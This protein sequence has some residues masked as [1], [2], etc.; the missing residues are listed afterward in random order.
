M[1]FNAIF[2]PNLIFLTLHILQ[3]NYY[4]YQQYKYDLILI[5]QSKFLIILNT[6]LQINLIF[7]KLYKFQQIS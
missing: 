6:I 2:L 3:L 7:L 4:M 5:F 1:I